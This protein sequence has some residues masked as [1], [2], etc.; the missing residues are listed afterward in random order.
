MREIQGCKRTSLRE[1]KNKILIMFSTCALKHLTIKHAPDL[2]VWWCGI[3]MYGT[4]G[5]VFRIGSDKTE[6]IAQ[7]IVSSLIRLN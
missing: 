4:R 7:K 1:Q 5:C 2:S 3:S 6:K